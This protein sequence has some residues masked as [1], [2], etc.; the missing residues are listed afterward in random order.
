M[1]PECYPFVV[2]TLEKRCYR[3]FPNELEE[4]ELILFHATAAEKL[5]AILKEG[6]R[7]GVEVGGSLSTISYGLN[8]MVALTHWISIRAKG[9][10]GVILALRFDNRD[11]IFEDGGTLHSRALIK[12][13]EVI[14]VCKIPSSYEHR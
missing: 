14:G 12:Q 11:E 2:E 3:T 10:D 13:P 7:P 8:S 5:V 4:D 9:T 1:K 6:L